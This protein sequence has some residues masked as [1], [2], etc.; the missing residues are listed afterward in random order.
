LQRFQVDKLK[1]DK[2]FVGKL[3]GNSQGQAIVTAIIQMA[4]SLQLV[5]TAEGIE[6]EATR[7]LL[8]SLGC[9]QAQGYWF[10]RPLPAADFALYAQH[11]AGAIQTA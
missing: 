1:I 8:A 10:A 7:Q 2:S 4:K 3:H 5:T 11:A 6:D 9:D